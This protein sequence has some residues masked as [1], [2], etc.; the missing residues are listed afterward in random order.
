M[1]LIS[2]FKKY[3]QSNSWNIDRYTSEFT[4]QFRICRFLQS[5]DSNFMIELESNINRY[6]LE[7]FTKKEID[8]DY[9]K[10]DDKHSC[11]EL[12]YVRDKGSYNIGMFSFYEDIKFVEEL[13]ESGKFQNGYCILFTSIKELYTPPNKKLN[14]KNKENIRLYDSFRV[15]KQLSGTVSIKTGPL[16]KSIS[17]KG[18]YNLNWFDFQD[19]I[20][21]CVLNI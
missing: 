20:K 18:K 4:L 19:D 7:K 3:S 14:P 11:I 6:S 21:C 13:V 5:I 10:N 1:F 12:K 9:Y 8:I 16:N 15:K 17:I 2:E